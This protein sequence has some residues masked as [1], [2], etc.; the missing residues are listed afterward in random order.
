[1]NILYLNAQSIVKKVDELGCV[2][3]LL[4]PDL[5]LVTKSWC[6]EDRTNA[7]LTIHGYELVPDLR[8]DRDNTARGR[9]GRSA[10]VCKNIV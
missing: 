5:I 9:G 4:K 6:N 8:M 1:M 2:S 7:Y 10:S 3:E